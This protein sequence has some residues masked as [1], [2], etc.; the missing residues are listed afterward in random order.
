MAKQI[1]YTVEVA[2]NGEPRYYQRNVDGYIYDILE[3][4][5]STVDFYELARWN[6]LAKNDFVNGSVSA[7]DV[8]ELE[9]KVK[10]ANVQTEMNDAVIAK[11]TSKLSQ[12]ER[13]ALGI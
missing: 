1:R 7:Y 4:A 11:A 12:L 3:K 9:L 13:D 6:D 10:S 8:V 5:S 2:I